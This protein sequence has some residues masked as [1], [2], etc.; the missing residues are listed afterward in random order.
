MQWNIFFDLHGTLVNS[1]LARKNYEQYLIKT[2]LHTGLT[3]EE[4]VSL[5]SKA[6]NDWATKVTEIN[7]DVGI[8]SDPDRFMA[9][10]KRF[11]K[12]WEDYFLSRI[13][14]SFREELSVK[15]RTEVVEYQ[16]LAYGKFP[17]LYPEAEK[18]IKTLH[19]LSEVSLHIASSASSNHIKGIV[20]LHKFQPFFKFLVGYDTVKAPKRGTLGIYYKNLIKLTKINPESIIFV[21]DSKEE[22]IHSKRYNFKFIMATLLQFWVILLTARST[23]VQFFIRMDK[24][25]LI[26]LVSVYIMV[27][28]GLILGF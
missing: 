15:L 27:I 20:H 12:E 18:V 8:E 3:R 14:Q 21:G 1:S 4:I 11:D 26:S 6:F 2:L 22:A 16:A 13:S 25:G 24:A 23:S 10:M 19:S 17:V 7:Q 9:L 5:H 28:L